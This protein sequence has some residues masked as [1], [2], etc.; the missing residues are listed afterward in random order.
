MH[1][2][3]VLELL[4]QRRFD[5]PRQYRYAVLIALTIPDQYLAPGKVHILDEEPHALEKG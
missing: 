3:R 1:L 4:A 2:P 5:R